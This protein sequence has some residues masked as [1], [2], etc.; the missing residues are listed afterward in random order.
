MHYLVV[1]NRPGHVNSLRDYVDIRH[2]PRHYPAVNDIGWNYWRCWSH[3]MCH[4]PAAGCWYFESFVAAG[5]SDCY[6]I[7]DYFRH[8]SNGNTYMRMKI[9]W[10]E[11]TIH[12]YDSTT[13]MNV[14]KHRTSLLLFETLL[15]TLHFECIYYLHK[16]FSLRNVRMHFQ[17]NHG[18]RKAVE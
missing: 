10:G 14:E 12:K 1:T 7:L 2:H 9:S 8:G 5:A 11:Q 17:V 3:A 13:V 6:E 16:Y 15:A 4:D 18:Q